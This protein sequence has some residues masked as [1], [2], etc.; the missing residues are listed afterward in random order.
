M[1]ST[2]PLWTENESMELPRA[3]GLLD[4]DVCVVGLGGSGLACVNALVDAGHRVIGVDAVT[5]A[6]GAAGRNGGFLLGGLALFH[7]DVVE[8]LGANAAKEIYDATLAQID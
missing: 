4:A 6:S 1:V 8:R 5:I 3:I 7:H 2:N